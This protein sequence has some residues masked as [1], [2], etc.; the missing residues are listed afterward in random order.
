MK[1]DKLFAKVDRFFAGIERSGLALT[2]GDV[3]LKTGYSD[4][5]P[6]DA[7]ITSFF[8][9]NVPLNCPLVSAAMDTVTEASMAI[10]MAMFGG[11][12]IIHK[13]LIAEQQAAQV[14]QV[15]RYLNCMVET[16]ICVKEDETMGEILDRSLESGFDFHS[17]PVLSNSGKIVGLLT[18]NN[19]EFCTDPKTTA[20]RAMTPFQDLV[21]APSG[22]SA[23][24]AYSILSGQH[25]KV[26]PLINEA[27]ELTGMFVYSDLKRLMFGLSSQ[28][29]VDTESHLRVGA[30]IDVGPEELVRA[31][32]LLEAGCDVLVIDKAH[33]DMRPVKEMLANLKSLKQK[34]PG[35]DVVAGNISEPESALNL[36]KWGA[37][38]IKVGQGPG[39][40]CTTRDIAGVGCPQ[41]TAVYNCAKAVRGMGIPLCADGG[42]TKSGDIPVALAVGA[43]SVMMGFILAGTDKA[44]GKFKETNRGRVKVYRG[45]GSLEAMKE[46]HAARARYRQGDT[47]KDKLV[48]EGVVSTVPYRG[49]ITKV[50]ETQVGGL[51]A[52]LGYVGAN[53]IP[54]L[55]KKADLHWLSAAGQTE[56]HPHDVD[57]TDKTQ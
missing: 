49:S 29:N 21:T 17:F 26:L 55:Q 45:M 50:L 43:S 28:Y 44:P 12:G 13:A 51:H 5:D 9:R 1:K 22:T 3:R 48:A 6:K 35:R 42:I 10:S 37:D 8:S 11:L 7:S 18:R 19:F 57:V 23:K 24:E 31:E 34:Y 32:M 14:R 53:S 52:G 56:S 25:K 46:S 4:S 16:P 33:G 27:R 38:G 2:Y 36:A 20:S 40:I 30:A 47:P 39:S 41:V 15:K 54:E